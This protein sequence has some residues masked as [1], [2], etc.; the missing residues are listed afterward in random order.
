MSDSRAGDASWASAPPLRPTHQ[1]PEIVH[2]WI[3]WAPRRWR[4]SAGPWTDLAAG[5]LRALDALDPPALPPALQPAPPDADDGDSAPSAPLPDALLGCD[6]LLYLPPVAPEIVP[7]HARLANGLAAAGVPVLLQQPVGQRLPSA[8]PSSSASRA[9]ALPPSAAPLAAAVTVVHDLLPVRLADYP[10]AALDAACAALPRGAW[11][12]WPLVPGRLDAPAEQ[13]A[14]CARLARAGVV[15]VHPL[16][17]TLR[18]ID[19]RRLAEGR[20]EAVFHRL[21]HAAP[22]DE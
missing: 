7:A 21:F 1:L 8:P 19:R 17:P 22:P 20:E 5:C 18:P 13:A 4:A 11:V 16:A 14:A 3:A 2:G 12:L 10:G 6:D 9:D 15:G